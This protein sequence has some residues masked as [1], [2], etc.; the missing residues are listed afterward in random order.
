VKEE[1]KFVNLTPHEVVVF[2]S[3]QNIILKIP[4]SGQTARVSVTSMVIGEINGIPVRRTIYGDVI[5]LP[6]PRDN[7]F[8]V[9]STLVLLALKEKGIV[10]GDVVAPDTSIDSVVRDSEGRI[11][12]VR[13][14]QVV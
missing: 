1:V 9:V 2:D 4:P 12:G 3:G 14:F 11:I 5:G 13:Y 6:E 7:T 8:Y 10:R